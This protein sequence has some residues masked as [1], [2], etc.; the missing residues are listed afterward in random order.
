[1]RF[2]TDLL[3]RLRFIHCAMVSPFILPCLPFSLTGEQKGEKLLKRCQWIVLFYLLH[4]ANGQTHVCLIASSV[5]IITKRTA[6]MY[7]FKSA[8]MVSVML[9]LICDSS[10]VFL[11]CDTP[12]QLVLS[13]EY[14]DDW[15]IVSSCND[16][17][18]G[19]ATKYVTFYSWTNRLT[20]FSTWNLSIQLLL[21]VN[22]CLT[23]SII[24]Y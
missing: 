12:I 11:G 15:K 13:C 21:C 19:L 24:K 4:H 18:H 9:R 6:V 20:R 10:S 8:R 2:N 7:Q 16:S 3:F 23:T 5:N 1:M 14:D 17:C 22:K